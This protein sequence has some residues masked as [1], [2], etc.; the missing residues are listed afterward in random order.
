V[1]TGVRFSPNA[2]KDGGHL[3]LR[4][5]V[6]QY[7]NRGIL[8]CIDTIS[9][10]NLLLL[11]HTFTEAFKVL[12]NFCSNFKF[13]SSKQDITIILILIDKIN[14]RSISWHKILVIMQ[15]TK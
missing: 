1:Y 4:G 6:R 8:S 5:T 15:K 7:V 14:A 2:T 10:L 13:K 11:V 3:K 12:F 9:G